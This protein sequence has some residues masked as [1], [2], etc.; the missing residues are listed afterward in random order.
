MR[1]EDVMDLSSSAMVLASAD[2]GS[3][4]GSITACD[5]MTQ[6]DWPSGLERRGKSV[7]RHREDGGN[8]GRR[9]KSAPLSL[10]LRPWAVLIS[11]ADSFASS[12]S[13]EPARA[14]ST[15]FFA[16][17]AETALI[18]FADHGGAGL[19]LHRSRKALRQRA[20]LRAPRTR[21]SR[22]RERSASFSTPDIARESRLEQ[23]RL[24]RNRPQACHPCPS[25][26][27]STCVNDLEA[28]PRSAWRFPR[29]LAL[30]RARHPRRHHR[31]TGFPRRPS[32]ASTAR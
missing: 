14:R 8:R 6:A 28:G 13:D 16:F 25:P 18:F 15:S 12:S 10:R 22:C 2:A 32:R 1:S 24:V 7:L 27:A 19:L 17:S 5:W 30:R 21:H 26:L 23:L 20:R 4:G 9:P 3:K 29:S 31:S 11:A